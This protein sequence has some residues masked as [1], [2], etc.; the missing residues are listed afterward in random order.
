MNNTSIQIIEK[1]DWISWEDIKQCLYEAHAPNREHGI[2][3]SHYL[4]PA[5]KMKQSLGEN[6]VMLVALDGRKIVGT[7]GY[8][9]K[10]HKSWYHGDK[11][12]Y[13]CFDGVIPSYT[14][15]GIFGSL[16]KIR[17][18]KIRENGYST[19]VFDT[20]SQNVRRQKKAIKQGYKYVSF[21]KA[22]S[23]DHYSV[24]MVKWLKGRKYSSLY[25]E[26]RFYLSKLKTIVCSLIK[27]NEG[28]K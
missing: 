8:V 16:D 12:A 11:Y 18:E 4:W 21:F 13:A 7:A 9:E 28:K 14:G 2:N 5:E 23:G 25:I 6:G 22:K 10:M 1:P 24:I 19:I 20:H 26:T 3:M 15:K 17:E 27:K